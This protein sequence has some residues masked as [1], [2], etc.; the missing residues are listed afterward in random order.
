M[1]TGLV[2]P[3]PNGHRVLYRAPSTEPRLSLAPLRPTP[4]PGRLVTLV[5][6]QRRPVLRAPAHV[7]AEALPPGAAQTC[8]GVAGRAGERIGPRAPD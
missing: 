3:P 5:E 6:L 1:E 4:R 2:R 8:G 7:R